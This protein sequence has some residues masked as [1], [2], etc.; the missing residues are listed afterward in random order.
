MYVWKDSVLPSS[1]E[2]RPLSSASLQLHSLCC[3]SSRC[4]NYEITSSK[5]HHKFKWRLFWISECA[6]LLIND[7]SGCICIMP[8]AS[9]HLNKNNWVD[10][11]MALATVT[12]HLLTL[13]EVVT[14]VFRTIAAFSYQKCWQHWSTPRLNC[15]VFRVIYLPH[16]G[17]NDLA[18]VKRQHTH[19]HSQTNWSC[20]CNSISPI[21][22]IRIFN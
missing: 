12:K 5:L 10:E 2:M 22:L 11:L 6:K 7:F 20:F 14:A 1:F 9:I 15:P 17:A 13:T 3:D 4:R 21:K 8:T 19:R 16:P 18:A